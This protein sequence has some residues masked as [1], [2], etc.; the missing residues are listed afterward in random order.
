MRLIELLKKKNIGSSTLEVLYEY[1]SMD[2]P[3]SMNDKITETDFN[4]IEKIIDSE[5]FN[6]YFRLLK[7]LE[8]QRSNMIKNIVENFSPSSIL[9]TI[10]KKL[11]FNHILSEYKRDLDEDLTLCTIL[12]D[13]ETNNFNI[14]FCFDDNF[15]FRTKTTFG[16]SKGL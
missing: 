15:M 11:I 2:K 12:N 1:L 13:N 3:F 16:T 14:N 5:E 6:N 4:F 8:E 10:E 9:N 7:Q